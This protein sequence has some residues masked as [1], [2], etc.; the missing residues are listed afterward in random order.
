LAPL[1]GHYVNPSLGAAK[2]SQ[3]GDALVVQLQVTGAT[4]KLEPWD[5]DVFVARL[6]PTG[7]FGPIVDLGYMTKGFVQFQ[8]DKDGKLDV[9]RLS[10]ENGQAYEFRR[11]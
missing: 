10:S 9:L 6:M 11:E 4:F 5:G 7:R 3:D 2:V 1:A 8:I